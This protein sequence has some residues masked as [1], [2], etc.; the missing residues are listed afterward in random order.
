[1]RAYVAYC[2]W[3]GYWMSMWM[4]WMRVWVWMCVFQPASHPAWF[5]VSMVVTAMFVSM[6]S[7]LFSIVSV[8]DVILHDDHVYPHPAVSIPIRV[9]YRYHFHLDL[10]I[11]WVVYP[12]QQNHLSH[13]SL[14]YRLVSLL[15]YHYRYHSHSHHVYPFSYS[16]FFSSSVVAPVSV[17]VR[18]SYACMM[19]NT[20]HSL[21][22][23]SI[24]E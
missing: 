8:S 4:M 17:L 11:R 9:D 19:D 7:H 24:V 18:S 23:M 1:M 20:I 21:E 14:R 15:R 3:Y 12:K 10:H 22:Y 16:F 2:G 5:D 13:T 6:S